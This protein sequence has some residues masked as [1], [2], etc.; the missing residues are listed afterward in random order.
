MSN[1]RRLLD[2]GMG[3]GQPLRVL[4]ASGQLGYGIPEAALR[5]GFARQPHFVGCDMGSIDVG[6]YYLG[7]GRLATSDAITRRDLRLVLNAALSQGVPLAIGTAGTAGA[8]PHLEATLAMVRDIARE[9]GLN[10]RLAVVESDM[11]REFL[12]RMAAAGRTWPLGNIAPLDDDIIDGASHIVGQIGVEAFARAMALDPDVIITG[13]ACDTAVFAAVPF[14]LGYDKAA[15]M[16]MAKIIECTSICCVPGGRDAILGTLEG[17]SFVLDSMNPLR[18][19]T[20]SSVAAHSLYEQDD[21]LTVYEPDGVLHVGDAHFE[22]VD[23][24]RTRVRG[25]R[26]EEARMPT[27]KIE[28][29]TYVGERAVLVAGSCDPQ[30]ILQSDAII[31]GVKQNVA[32]IL[33][34][35]D[36]GAYELIFHVYGK[37]EINLF[38]PQPGPP[39]REVFF[40]VE[41]IADSAD[42]AKAAIGVTK[43]YLLHHGF[44]GRLS[45][46]GNIAFPFTPPELPANSVYRFS[47]YH[48]TECDDQAALF[49]VRVEQV[50]GGGAGRP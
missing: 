22:A 47:V 20:P 11:P 37:D 34:A 19:A 6:P 46:G 18:A 13:R 26:W 29:S 25:A 7:S 21:P 38:S 32:G 45:T 14:L 12:K 33:D 28:G 43:Q 27:V 9:D 36:Q 39:P 5:A 17:E 15:A 50:G 41:C 2:S 44:E 35:A 3:P 40:L 49:P 8:R 48:V 10:F 30:V 16:H 23:E 31:V 42:L 1:F 24:H 4:A